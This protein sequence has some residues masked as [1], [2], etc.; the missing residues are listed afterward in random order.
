MF[1]WSYHL[2]T[3]IRNSNYCQRCFLLNMVRSPAS[4]SVNIYLILWGQAQMQVKESEFWGRGCKLIKYLK[5]T[6]EEVWAL[7]KRLE[8]RE[9]RLC[10]RRLWG[11]FFFHWSLL[12][13]SCVVCGCGCVHTH[14]HT[15]LLLHCEH[16][17]A[18]VLFPS[19]FWH[20]KQL[21]WI[22]WN[23]ESE[24]NT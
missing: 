13:W 2:F 17:C 4:E 12:S 23:Q 14:A 24:Y 22:I 7:E 5:I 19:I 11:W 10:G 8:F 9:R 15:C 3:L 21:F 20:L 18:F 16:Y 6:V 1:L